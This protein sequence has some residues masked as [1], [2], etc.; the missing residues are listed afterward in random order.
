MIFVPVS[1][2]L[3]VPTACTHR[4]RR[5]S[6]PQRS[7]VTRSWFTSST[8]TFSIPGLALVVKLTCKVHQNVFMVKSSLYMYMYIICFIYLF[9]KFLL[10][11]HKP[12]R[13]RTVG[14]DFV[15]LFTKRLPLCLSY[16]Y[17][18]TYSQCP[19]SRRIVCVQYYI[20]V[21]VVLSL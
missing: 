5:S 13:V 18:C 8:S 11:L 4:S 14:K 15:E 21:C 16:G 9:L 17:I 3:F 2:F 10:A 19:I 20:L 7:E 12:V 1:W 6:Q